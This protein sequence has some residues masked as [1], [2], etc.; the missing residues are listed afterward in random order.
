[1]TQHVEEGKSSDF[2][3]VIKA[4]ENAKNLVDVM[5]T[6]DFTKDLDLLFKTFLRFVFCQV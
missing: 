4:E 5:N 6:P 3:L 2:M 1:M